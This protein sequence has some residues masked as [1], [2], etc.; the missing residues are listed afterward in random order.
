MK[1]LGT[2]ILMTMLAISTMAQMNTERIT[3]IGRNALYFE[4]YVL[5]IQYFNQVIKLKPYLS[6]P[7][8]LRAIAKI[9]LGDYQGALRDINFAID[10]NPFQPGCYYTRGYIYRQTDDPV[11][12]EEDFTQAL[13]FA[14]YHKTYML[15]RA[16][17]RARQK[18][19]T[20]ALEDIDYLLGREPHA[21]N[22]LFEKGV[23][24]M[25]QKDTICALQQ[26][27]DATRYD[28]QNAGNWSAKGMVLLTMGEDEKALDALGQS[29]RLGSRWAGDYINR[30]IIYYRQHNYRSA[31]ADYDR[32]IEIAP[33]SAECYYNRAILRQ[34]LGDYNR[35]IDDYN[36]A[37]DLDEDRAE[38]RY[39]RATALMQLSQWEAARE[40]FDTLIARYPY[41]LPAY[42]L[43]AQT[44]DQLRAKKD[45]F[46]YR[47][48][49]MDIESKK[50]SILAAMAARGD[51]TGQAPNT[52]VQIAKAE[53]KRDRRKEFSAR[54][55]QGAGVNT[56]DN[57]NDNLGDNTEP[58]TS[59]I[60]GAVQRRYAEVKSEGN[61]VLSYYA[62]TDALRRTNYYHAEVDRYNRSGALPSP[63]RFTQQEIPLSA[64]MAAQHFAEISR[65]SE[66]LETQPTPELHFARA[67]EFALVQDYM[68]A[69]DDATQAIVGL[70]DNAP[71]LMYFCRANWRYKQLEYQRAMGELNGAS[72]LDFE[73]MLRDWEKTVQVAPDFAMAHYNRAN[74]LAMQRNYKD[75]IRAYSE[76]IAVDEE[77]AE[78]YYNRGLTYIWLGEQ[79]KG[80]DDLS[81][82]GELGMYQAYGVMER[83]R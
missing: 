49:A 24:C 42:Y 25:E 19:Y 8:Q 66:R 6:E 7:Y 57:T 11:R 59:G 22:L 16:D 50:D 26:F 33:N 21:P 48:T 15:L 28:S 54:E 40:D 62:Q 39:Q 5:S 45:A 56:N 53:K 27:T 65:L 79:E 81:R 31:L 46:R 9:Q 29:I 47:Q 82:A 60:R 13:R 52:D 2:L 14:P 36:R 70:G 30:G 20:E 74:I 61:I 55:A 71:A 58:G 64:E 17:V 38:M 51:E 3:A 4:D 68:S 1:K 77:F 69:L 12:A 41:F 23:I 35:A 34:E 63:L 18:H 83:V 44:A 78:A 32:A 37:I 75:A 10:L 43:A 73:I 72:P 80:M 76:A 67:M